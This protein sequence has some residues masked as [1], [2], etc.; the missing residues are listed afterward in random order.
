MELIEMKT[1]DQLN[2]NQVQ[3]LFKLMDSYNIDRTP[4]CA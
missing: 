3:A 2:I 1:T 4:A